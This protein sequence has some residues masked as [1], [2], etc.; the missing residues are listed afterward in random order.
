[1]WVFA[2][3]LNDILSIEIF[4]IPFSNQSLCQ[5]EVYTGHYKTYGVE[6]CNPRHRPADR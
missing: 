5:S 4:N 6:D 3:H 2:K 1:M